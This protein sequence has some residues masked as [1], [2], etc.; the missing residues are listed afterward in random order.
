[1]DS[2]PYADKRAAA[3]R[4]LAQMRAIGRLGDSWLLAKQQPRKTEPKRLPRLID[5]RATDYQN[6]V[7]ML[8][9]RMAG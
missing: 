1:M 6:E 3:R 5:A 4:W 8:C 2:Y 7:P 9:R